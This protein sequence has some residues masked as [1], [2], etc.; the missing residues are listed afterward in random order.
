[1]DARKKEVRLIFSGKQGWSTGALPIRIYRAK[2][3][4]MPLDPGG[5]VFLVDLALEKSPGIES[6]SSTYYALVHG[7]L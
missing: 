3:N 4:V 5:R 2:Q 6:S 7:C 1:V